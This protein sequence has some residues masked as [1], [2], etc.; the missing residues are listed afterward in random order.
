MGARTGCP[1]LSAHL[2]TNDP[3]FTATFRRPGVEEPGRQITIQIGAAGTRL[4]LGGDVLGT[5]SHDAIRFSPEPEPT[6]TIAGEAW[7]LDLDDVKAFRTAAE[8][9]YSPAELPP[10]TAQPPEAPPSSRPPSVAE[11]DS[12]PAPTEARSPVLPWHALVPRQGLTT[13]VF[14]S[15][16]AVAFIAVSIASGG[17]LSAVLGFSAGGLG[18]AGVLAWRSLAIAKRSKIH[19]PLGPD[20][21]AE[22]RIARAVARAFSARSLTSTLEDQAIEELTLIKGI[23]PQYA[24]MLIEA[25][26]KS[27]ESLAHITTRQRTDLELA[28]GRHSERVVRE[29]WVEQARRILNER[30]R[31]HPFG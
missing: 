6:M 13:V 19:S 8:S 14:A 15:V 30:S 10:A 3:T 27:I 16:A 25:G 21:D 22:A 12:A 17:L 31:S 1:V 18:L 4:S 26:V 7:L 9:H 5:W 20:I 2:M 24:Q 11:D 29:G 23:G 28:L